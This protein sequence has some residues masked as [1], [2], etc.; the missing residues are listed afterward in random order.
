MIFNINLKYIQSI[1]FKL[2]NKYLLSWNILF[3]PGISD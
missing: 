1:E 3:I 2:F